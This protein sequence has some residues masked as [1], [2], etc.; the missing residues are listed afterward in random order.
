M[1][2]AIR[3]YFAFFRCKLLTKQ[4]YLFTFRDLALSITGTG[5]HLLSTMKPL[6]IFIKK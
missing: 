3:Y 6:K 1:V 4:A 2:Y 5:L